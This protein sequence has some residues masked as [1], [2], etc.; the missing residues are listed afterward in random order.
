VTL[1][2]ALVAGQPAQITVNASTAGKLDAW[3]DFN[4]DDDWDDP[5]EQIFTSEPL[6]A[7]DNTLTFTVPTNSATGKTF[8]RF[9]LS[10]VGGLQP[11]GF[12]LDGEVEDYVWTLGEQASLI[13]ELAGADKI[14]DGA[15][16]IGAIQDYARGEIDGAQLIQIIQ[17]YATGTECDQP[18]ST[19]TAALAAVPFA[20][21]DISYDGQ[22][23]VAEGTGI[24]AIDVRGYNLAG[25]TV[26][27]GSATGNILAFTGLSSDGHVLANGVYL[28]TMIAYGVGGEVARSRVQK[29]VLLR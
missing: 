19:T 10:S 23:F 22:A 13:C 15:D 20:L 16:L 21:E 18:L 25:Q 26:F 24:A 7:G 8:A 2:T 9:R 4:K 17:Y 27:S 3:I 1:N 5:G 6:A 14:V 11:T 12:A 28:Y 29:L